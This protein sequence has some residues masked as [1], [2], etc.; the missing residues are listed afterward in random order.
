M[1]R[2]GSE[3]TMSS[4]TLIG[5]HNK[6]IRLMTLRFLNISIL[7]SL[8][9]AIY[10]TKTSTFVDYC[11][12]FCLSIYFTKKSV[13]FLRLVKKVLSR[14][15]QNG[16]VHTYGARRHLAE[17]SWGVKW[18]WSVCDG[19]EEGIQHLVPSP[20]VTAQLATGQRC[21]KSSLSFLWTLL[22]PVIVHNVQLRF[23][24][25]RV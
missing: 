5:Y 7:K 23:R 22:L 9:D 17:K 11:L 21:W 19:M 2:V 8:Y 3:N 16:D 4:W 10:L 25:L 14:I 24:E 20:L 15:R 18:I 6:C 12:W 13:H 1:C